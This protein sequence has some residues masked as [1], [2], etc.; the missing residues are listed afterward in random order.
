MRFAHASDIHLG[1]QDGA[2][3]QG[4]EREVF[5]KVIDGCISRKVDFVLMPGD[6]F[7]VN[8]PEMRV[9][10]FAFAGFR[11]LHEA[12]IPVYVVYGS[13]DFSPVYNSVIDLLAETGYI[14][15]V[16]LPE[17]TDDGKIRLGLVTDDKTGAMIAGL[18]GLKSG[19]D[20]E[21]Y[22]RLDRENIPQGDGFKIFLFHGGITEAK[23]DERYNEGF[24]PASLLPR[25]FDY[26]AGGHLHKF[27]KIGDA[28]HPIVYPG[29]PF[30]GQA[31][32]LEDNARGARRGFVIVDTGGDRPAVEFVEVRGAE[33]ELIEV[34]AHNRNAESVDTGLK[35]AAKG[36]SPERKVVIIKV[37]GELS[38]G[39][40]ADVDIPAVRDAMVKGAALAVKVSRNQLTS[41]EYRITDAPGGTR[42]ETERNTFAENIGEVRLKRDG[43]VGEQGV[44]LACRLLEALRL[45]P[46]ANEK[47]ADYQGRMIEGALKTMGLKA[48]DS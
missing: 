18:S 35:E 47:K 14:T 23:T 19:R 17:V 7:H 26:Y 33:Y 9:Q 45:P 39:R 30:A 31:V 34:D 29:T 12:G 2:A 42:E 10:K 27:I 24:M 46:L 8:I 15:R 25:G 3:L 13:H 32:D 38:S 16:Q 37:T 44:E 43:L 22:A 41:R 36:V 11:R 21:Y 1:F 6:I 5:E 40:T 20:E 4:I 28:D 48:D